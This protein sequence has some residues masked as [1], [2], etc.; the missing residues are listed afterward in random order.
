MFG[1]LAI[2]LFSL[3]LGMF[4]SSGFAPVGTSLALSLHSLVLPAVSL[5]LGLAGVLAR[6]T[7]SAMLDVLHTDY[8][9]FARAN[10]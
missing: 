1:I 3:V 4:P 2:L 9:R 8:A 10:G 5:G 6:V 7:R